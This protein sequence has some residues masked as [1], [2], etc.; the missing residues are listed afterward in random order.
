MSEQASTMVVIIG[1]AMTAGSKPS[2]FAPIGSRQ[3]TSIAMM[4]VQNSDFDRDFS[5]ISYDEVPRIAASRA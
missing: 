4:T 5:D 2:F 1:L 3:P